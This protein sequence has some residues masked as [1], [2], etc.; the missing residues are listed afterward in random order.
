[1]F[2]VCW[3]KVLLSSSL[4][5]LLLLVVVVVVVVVVV[6]VAVVVVCCVS[7]CYVEDATNVVPTISDLICFKCKYDLSDLVCFNY[8]WFI[9]FSQFVLMSFRLYLI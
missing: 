7:S 5:L 8:I 2:Y 9:W 4:L 1:M 3:C 6:A